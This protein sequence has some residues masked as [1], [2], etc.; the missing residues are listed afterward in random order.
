MP[1]LPPSW[2]NRLNRPAAFGT[3]RGG[4]ERSVASESGTII[5][6]IARPRRICGMKSWSQPDWS[7]QACMPIRLATMV[8]MPTRIMRRGPT[9]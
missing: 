5:M 8:I 2:R 1:R 7:D 9:R 6:P 3:S 4:S